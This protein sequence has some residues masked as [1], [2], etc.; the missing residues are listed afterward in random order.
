MKLSVL[1]P[2]IEKRKKQFEQLRNYVL[3]I[4]EPYNVEVLSLC[5]NQEMS[6]GEKK[7][8]LIQMSSGDYVVTIDDD[9]SVCADYFDIIMPILNQ[10]PDCIG[11]EVSLRGLDSMKK[12]CISTKYPE[13]ANNID[14]YDLVRYS[15]EKVPIKREHAISAGFSWMRYYDDYC[16]SMNLKR[17]GKLKNEIFIPKEMYIYQYEAGESYDERYGFNKIYKQE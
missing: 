4:S 7:N 14:G 17:D 16:F 1:I 3:K 2:T 11:Y 12:A 10:N 15:H 8:K 5:D 6:T 13:W 9:D